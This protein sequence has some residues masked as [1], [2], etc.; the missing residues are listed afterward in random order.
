MTRAGDVAA[1]EDARN[2]RTAA[3]VDDD[4]SVRAER[5]EPTQPPGRRAG[6]H[7]IQNDATSWLR[8][9][10]CEAHAVLKVPFGEESGD[11]RPQQPL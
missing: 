5:D 9:A 11:L 2:R 4:A 3:G 8:A 6:A 1:C 10:R 7:C